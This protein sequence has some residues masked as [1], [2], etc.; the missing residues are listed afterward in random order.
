MARS[1]GFECIKGWRPILARFLERFEAALADLPPDVRDDFQI[2]Q[3]KQEF[4]RLTIYLSTEGTA[5]MQAAIEEAADTS[6]VTCEVCSAPGV[7]DSRHG[8]TSVRCASH[9][10]WSRVDDRY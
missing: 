5:E 3:I 7:L 6:L 1:V 9:E 4:G 2:V 10:S 8:W